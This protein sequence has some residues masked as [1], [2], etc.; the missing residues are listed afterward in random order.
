MQ[1]PLCASV[2]FPQQCKVKFKQLYM[3]YSMWLRRSWQDRGV[4]QQQQQLQH[5]PDLFTRYLQVLCHF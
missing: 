2:A 1:D 3:T 4:L 5:I